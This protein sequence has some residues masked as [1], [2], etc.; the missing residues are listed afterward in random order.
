MKCRWEERNNTQHFTE[1][2]LDDDNDDDDVRHLCKY[3]FAHTMNMDDKIF[4][5]SSSFVCHMPKST[6]LM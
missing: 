2:N 6:S 5:C 3:Y 1:S 4:F